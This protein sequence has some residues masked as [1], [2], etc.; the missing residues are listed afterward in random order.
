MKQ[1][2]KTSSNNDSKGSAI[3]KLKTET[4]HGIW[5]IVF[6]V[7][8]LFLFMSAFNMAGPAG[9]FFYK[10]LYLLLGVGYVLLPSLFILLGWS[11][12][13]AERPNIGWTRMISSIMFLLSG[14]SIID[15]ASVEH[16]GGLLG[17]ILSTPFVKLFDVYAS[18]IFL[19]A[20]LIIS[21]LIMFDAKPALIPF[22]KKIL[23]LFG[24]KS[25][26]EIEVEDDIEEDTADRFRS[27]AGTVGRIHR[28]GKRRIGKGMEKRP[29]LDQP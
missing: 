24:K 28:H 3:S 19:G 4:K 16:A 2:K 1:N 9:E 7:L 25:S 23:A 8:A 18:I 6:F 13:K 27:P 14:L 17:R 10:I 26:G 15:V 5:A 11:F 21:I 29:A 20:I 12:V 22:F